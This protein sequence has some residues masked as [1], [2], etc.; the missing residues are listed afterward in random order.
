MRYFLL[1]FGLTVVAVM[2][3]VGMPTLPEGRW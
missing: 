3:T 2:L 1:I